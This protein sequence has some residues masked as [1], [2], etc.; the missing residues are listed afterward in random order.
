MAFGVGFK[1]RLIVLDT[2]KQK[3]IS[4]RYSNLTIEHNSLKRRMQTLKIIVK[5]FESVL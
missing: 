3:Y 4:I 1:P 5:M 2:P